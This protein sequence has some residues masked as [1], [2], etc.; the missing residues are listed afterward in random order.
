VLPPPGQRLTTDH[1]FA[2]PTVPARIELKAAEACGFHTDHRYVLRLA[3]GTSAARAQPEE[4]TGLLRF[5][6]SRCHDE[7]VRAA[8]VSCI[9]KRPWPFAAEDSVDEKSVRLVEACQAI[10]AATLGYQRT[11]AGHGGQ[12]SGAA[13]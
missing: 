4:T 6:I 2:R 5:R 12:S 1:C 10:Q 8:M 11:R 7:A 13:V 3:L 9:R